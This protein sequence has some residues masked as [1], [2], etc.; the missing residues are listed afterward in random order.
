VAKDE[1]SVYQL[2]VTLQGIKPDIWR[3][4]LVDS[5]ASL[6][7]LHDVLQCA[8]GWGDS[9]LHELEAGG[10]SYSV[11]TPEFPTECI[12]T[13]K[14]QLRRVLPRVRNSMTYLY[15]FGDSWRHKIVLEKIFALPVP[16]QMPSCVAGAR[17]TPPEDCGGVYGYLNLLKVIAN[18]ED[19]E[20]ESMIEWLG[21]DF[22][23]EQ[24]DL[25]IINRLLMPRVS[26]RKKP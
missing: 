13:R 6:A 18:P 5:S 23:P 8:L 14:V 9:H 15:D 16:L 2:K 7:K 22:D 4:L 20:H 24:F 3:R 10:L 17:A 21:D 26:R 25:E 11:P 1:S 12:D 19:D